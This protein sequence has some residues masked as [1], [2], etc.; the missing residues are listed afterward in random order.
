MTDPAVLRNE[1]TTKGGPRK[2]KNKMLTKQK[3][4]AH[5]QR[6]E[7]VFRAVIY[8][9]G[10]DDNVADLVNVPSINAQ[11]VACHHAAKGLRAEI[12]DEFVDLVGTP[13]PH[14]GM[15]K[16]MALIDQQPPDYLVVS[17]LD[18]LVLDRPGAFMIGWL[19]GSAD[20]VLVAANE[21]VDGASPSTGGEERS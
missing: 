10:V 1:I 4:K 13:P 18:R 6:R 5:D 20:T 17:S 19:L 8:M 7:K 14:L 3:R 12:V 15:E 11:R 9:R 21:E 16:L 2:E